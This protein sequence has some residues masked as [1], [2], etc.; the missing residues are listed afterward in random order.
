MDRDEDLSQYFNIFSK[1]F[2]L[3]MCSLSFSVEFMYH[4]VSE[5]FDGTPA[6]VQEQVLS[7]L[8]VEYIS[9]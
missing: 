3:D 9:L 1:T 2:D 8:Q 5:R 7:W 6:A 4:F